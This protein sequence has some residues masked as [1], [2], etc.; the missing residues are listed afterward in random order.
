MI[1]LAVL[2]IGPITY[3][4]GPGGFLQAGSGRLQDPIVLKKFK[5]QQA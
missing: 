5:E 1:D 2:P 3:I 4:R